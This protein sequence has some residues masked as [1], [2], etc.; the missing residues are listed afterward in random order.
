MY[1]GCASQTV[2]VHIRGDIF[3]LGIGHVFCKGAEGEPRNITVEE[4]YEREETPAIAEDPAEYPVEVFEEAQ[5]PVAD[6]VIEDAFVYE[7]PQYNS[8]A[9]DEEPK[10]WNYFTAPTKTPTRHLEAART[11]E[12]GLEFN[13]GF[14]NSLLGG[15]DIFQKELVIDLRKINDSINERGVGLNVDLYVHT[16]MN[17]NLKKLGMG[18]GEF[19]NV[20]GQVDITLPKSLF[21]LLASGNVKE[22]DQKGEFAVSGAVWAEAGIK[23]YMTFLGD[24]LRVGLT[25]AWYLPLVYV[26]KSTV[27]YTLETKDSF[28]ITTGADMNIYMPFTTDPFGMNNGG[29]FDISAAGEYALFPILD[30]GAAITHIPV[31]PA[32]LD[33]RMAVSFPDTSLIDLEGILKGETPE[34]NVPEP[35]MTNT[36]DAKKTVLRPFGMD[37]YVLFRP[38]RTDLLTVKPNL[39]FTVNNPSEEDYFNWGLEA[40]LN[41]SRIF[42]LYVNTGLNE[43]IW[44]HKAGFALNLHA[45]ELDLEAGLRSQNFAQSFKT[46]GLSVTLGMKFGW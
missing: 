34:I 22:Q 12:M 32:R 41:L 40:Q 44:R 18:F 13:V 8:I 30:V 17:L 45:F 6:P 33:N 5:V 31:V 46:S 38:L 14:A 26:P 4:D 16:F 1:G 43:G 23:G 25:P 2:Y 10:A 29:G 27:S 19:I 36:S 20:D 3:N 42:L 24:K 21:T 39:G 35:D 7:E 37:F 9:V 15:A 11:F 28:K